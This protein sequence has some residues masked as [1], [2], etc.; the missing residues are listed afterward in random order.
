[1][2]GYL[3]WLIIVVAVVILVPL[4]LAVIR[5]VDYKRQVSGKK[6]MRT[7][8]EGEQISGPE[9]TYN[10]EMEMLAAEAET[11]IKSNMLGMG[12]FGR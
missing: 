7:L 5:S 4:A 12:R 3:L 1:M 10:T 8:K 11:R 6:K 2:N 9:K